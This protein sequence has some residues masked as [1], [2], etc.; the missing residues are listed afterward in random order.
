[1]KI[2]FVTNGF[3]PK[4]W[5]GT[6]TYTAGIANGLKINGHNIQV[7]CCGE[8]KTGSKH[9]NGYTDDKYN[10]LPVRRLNLNWKNSPKPF[11][12]LYDNPAVGGF[13]EKYL[14][15]IRPDLVHVTSCET[16]SASVLDVVKKKQIPLVLSITDFWFLCPRINLLRSDGENCSGITNPWECLQCMSK[17]SKV[18]RWSRKVLPEKGAEIFLTKLSKFPVLT[19]QRGLRGMVGDMA[20]RKRFMR[21]VFSLPDIR[22]VASKF[23]RGVYKQNGFDDPIRLHPYGHDVSWLRDYRGKVHSKDL[24]VGFIGQIAHPKGV[25]LLLE[26]AKRLVDILGEKVKFL[27]YGNLHKHPEYALRLESLANGLE[28]VQF[29][30]TYPREM[31][32]DV[33]SKIDVLVVPSLWYDFP[34]I[35]HEAF[36]T[37][38]PVIATN[39]GGMAETVSHEVNG[40]LFERGNVDDLVYQI[41]RIVTEPDLIPKLKAGIPQVKTVQEDVSELEQIYIELF[42]LK[43]KY[44]IK[45]Q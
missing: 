28:T 33:F 22:L 30:G 43:A 40:L 23:V 26:A 21:R 34:L 13:L 2:L 15:E 41:Q 8:W 25:H 7:L 45:E 19:R 17:R 16:L 14:E 3:P 32:A 38:T 35:I 37:N 24:Q 6:E 5:S 10:D 42:R 4:R 44:Q 12:H 9:W 27:I 31:S 39:L 36:A 18:Y 11:R 29:R 1:M 20:N